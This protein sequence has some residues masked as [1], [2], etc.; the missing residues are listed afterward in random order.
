MPLTSAHCSTV[1]G[2]IERCPSDKIKTSHAQEIFLT[3]YASFKL[4]LV[5]ILI[6]RFFNQK[7]LI[8]GSQNIL[9]KCTDS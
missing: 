2:F 5:V 1:T 9:G 4:H 8:H 6:K 7:M 3:S